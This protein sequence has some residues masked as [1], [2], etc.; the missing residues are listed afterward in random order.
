MSEAVREAVIEQIGRAMMNVRAQLP[1]SA[2]DAPEY[3]V[4]N[5][6]PDFDDLPLHGQQGNEYDDITQEAV[7]R[8]AACAYDTALTAIA[9]AGFAVVPVTPTEAMLKAA[10]HYENQCAIHN[11]GGCADADGIYAAM[12]AA[13][14]VG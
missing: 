9:K 8:L 4:L 13:G 12:I 1:G 5:M 6:D 14:G 10:A 11:Y 3:P 2:P 7:L